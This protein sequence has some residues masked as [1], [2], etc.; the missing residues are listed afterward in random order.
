MIRVRLCEP[1][2]GSKI[3][4][5]IRHIPSPGVRQHSTP[6]SWDVQIYNWLIAEEND[7][8]LAVVALAICPP[9]G[10]F[11]QFAVIPDINKVTKARIVCLF[12]DNGY[13][14]LRVMGCSAACYFISEVHDYWRDALVRRGAKVAY[15]GELLVRGL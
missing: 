10:I 11:E 7:K 8:I 9:F 4:E 3:A 5:F 15:K 6:I 1:D 2:E 14:L 13:S 12:L